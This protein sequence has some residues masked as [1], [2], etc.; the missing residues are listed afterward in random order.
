MSHAISVKDAG[1]AQPASELA[2]AT[3][4]RRSRPDD[5]LTA[6][7]R[8]SAWRVEHELGRGGMSSVHAVVHTKF[9]KRAALKIAHR[10]VLGPGG[11]SAETFLREARITN[12]VE[13]PAVIDVFATGTHDGRPYLV[14]EK[15]AGMPLGQ[16]LD[17]GPPLPRHEALAILLELCHILRAAHAAGVV[18]RDLKLDN[19]FLCDTPF[20]DGRRV[21]LL[22]WG[23]AHIAGEDD[24]FRGLIAGTLTY[25]APE[26]IRGDALTGAADIYSLAVLAYHL[27]CGRPPFTGPDLALI[28]MH[29]RTEPPPP[30]DAWPDVPPAL[31]ALLLRMLAKQP[32]SRPSLD[33]VE[34]VLRAALAIVAQPGKLAEG[35]A[36]DLAIPPAEPSWYT[37]WLKTRVGAQ[38]AIDV[39]G[40]PLLPTPP[41]KMSWF[42]IS[43]AV[44]A[45]GGLLAA[46]V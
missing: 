20:A 7:A 31:D 39:L 19:V 35:S 41:V 38:V 24:P 11:M 14:M 40:R 27:L 46:L 37:R 9:G 32:E 36:A 22:D 23:V 13:H 3:P 1:L 45:L 2:D 8:V 4:R 44:G 25:V 10:S 30:R 43:L 12:T 26:Q 16:R 42:A 21:K 29:L 28:H 17:E 18:H 5:S 34:D 15:L 6:S 33:E